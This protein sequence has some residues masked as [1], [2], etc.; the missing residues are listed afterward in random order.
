MLPWVFVYSTDSNHILLL[1]ASILLMAPVTRV[2]NQAGLRAA[3][4]EV[5]EVS[6]AKR[7]AGHPPPLGH[8]AH[9]LPSPWGQQRR[10]LFQL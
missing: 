1:L 3:A 6:S 2:A 10:V 7:E 9:F 4:P 5:R 8:W